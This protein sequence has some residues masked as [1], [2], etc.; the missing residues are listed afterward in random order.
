MFPSNGS[1]SRRP[2][3]LPGS[4]RVRFPWFT[5][6]MRRSDSLPP[7][8]RASFPSL[9]DTTRHV[10]LFAPTAQTTDRGPGVGNPVA[11]AGINVW[12]GP[13]SLRFLGDP[14]RL[15][16]VLR[17]RSDRAHQAHSVCRH[18]PRI[19]QQRRL[20]RVEKFRGSIAGPVRWL[21][22]LRRVG[23]P[24]TAQDSLPAAGPSL[25]GRGC[26]P[27]GSQRKVSGD[28]SYIASSFPKLS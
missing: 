20:R 4:F 18:G 26:L 21:S 6:T 1:M 17:P 3:P 14:L 9:G 15:C 27:A 12:R 7:F 23:C 2:L 16:P 24:T 5:G 19:W 22:T 10:C 25:T 28:V 11:P 8:R 13:G